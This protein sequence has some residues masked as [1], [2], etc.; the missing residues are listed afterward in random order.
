MQNFGANI[1]LHGRMDQLLNNFYQTKTNPLAKNLTGIGL[2]MEGIENNPIMYELMCEL[3]WRQDKF[4]KEEWIT[5]YV[6]ARYGTYNSTIEKAW[7]LL[8]NTIYNCPA[9][10]NQQGA[11]ESIFCGR[12]SMDNFQ[13]S[14]WSKMENYYDPRSTDRK[15]VV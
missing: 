4:S 3:P 5:N 13:V 6:T 11:H 8:G 7:Q 12:P 9:G 15:S 1:G 2:T 14:S 10:N